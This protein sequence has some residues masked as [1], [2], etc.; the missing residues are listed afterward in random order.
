MGRDA[1]VERGKILNRVA[2]LIE[3]DA[4][5]LAR[6]EALDVGK[7]IGQPGMLDVPN[8]AG[9]FRHFAGWADKITGQTI[10]T[11]GYFGPLTRIR[12]GSRSG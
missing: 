5:L 12:C 10:P 4:D 7:P 6:L 1:G 11:A 3:R 9:T 2:D 8:A